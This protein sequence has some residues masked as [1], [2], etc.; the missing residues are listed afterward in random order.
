MNSISQITKALSNDN[1]KIL[2]EFNNLREIIQELNVG[3]NDDYDENYSDEDEE[4][5]N[6]SDKVAK[7]FNNQ[8][9]QKTNL[10]NLS[11][12]FAQKAGWECGSC[13]T[14]NDVDKN[15]CVACEIPKPGAVNNQAQPNATPTAFKFG[16]FSNTADFSH[17]PAKNET[18]Q[19]STSSASLAFGSF[20]SPSLQTFGPQLPANS[21]SHFGFSSAT[22]NSSS[23]SFDNLKPAA[24]AHQFGFS[25]LSSSS[26]NTGFLL[27]PCKNEGTA[28]L[29]LTP[30]KSETKSVLP[31]A[32]ASFLPTFSFN[33]AASNTP[34]SAL[35]SFG[36]LPGNSGSPFS[37]SGNTTKESPSATLFSSLNATSKSA[38][39]KKENED[40]KY[41]VDALNSPEKD[42]PEFFK[43]PDVKLPENY[44]QVTGEEHEEVLFDQRAKLFLLAEAEYKERG[45][46]LLKVLKHKETGKIRLL[47][48]R[49]VVHK[50]CLNV[51]LNPKAPITFQQKNSKFL[52][53]QCVDFS[54]EKPK[55]GLFLLRFKNNDINNEFVQLINKLMSDDAQVAQSDKFQPKTTNST[56]NNG[57]S[58][59]DTENDDDVQLIFEELPKPEHIEKAARLMLRPSFFNYENKPKCPGCIGCDDEKIDWN[60]LT[61]PLEEPTNVPNASSNIFSDLAAEIN[62]SENRIDTISSLASGETEF[63]EKSKSTTF[64]KCKLIFYYYLGFVSVKSKL[65]PENFEVKTGEEEE[66]VLFA[67]NARL[68]R[69]IDG[70]WK[71]RGR[72]VMKI[73]KRKDKGNNVY[74]LFYYKANFVLFR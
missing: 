32:P 13:S 39:E 1:V 61:K 37:F 5:S 15:C 55:P 56:N 11:E 63:E 10:P 24:N 68:Y 20:T 14:K 26:N 60:K 36:M 27:N 7:G 8:Q 34:K 28:S 23:F 42:G 16:G 40:D 59:T 70:E 66:D 69:F 41:D 12:C 64:Y 4:Y 45:I 38:A 65:L 18:P 19:Q 62:V 31:I 50:V 49:E 22:P 51:S 17:A 48:R 2:K 67:E 71:E 25:S 53:F 6:A 29:S 3:Q 74:I 44:K 73:L 33:E 47:M 21:A 30:N 58:K 9:F 46:G 43:L 72:G 52:A 35:P 54:D 57:D